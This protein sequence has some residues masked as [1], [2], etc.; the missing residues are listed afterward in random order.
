MSAPLPEKLCSWQLLNRLRE[1][2]LYISFDWQRG[3]TIKYRAA[4]D[5]QTLVKGVFVQL[6]GSFM[7]EGGIVLN[8]MIVTAPDAEDNTEIFSMTVSHCEELFCGIGKDPEFQWTQEEREQ[9]SFTKENGADAEL[10]RDQVVKIL[11]YIIAD[12]HDLKRN[13]AEIDWSDHDSMRPKAK[14]VKGGFKFFPLDKSSVYSVGEK[15]GEEVRAKLARG[16][17]PNAIKGHFTVE[18]NPSMEPG[19]DTLTFAL[20]E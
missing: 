13:G 19:D 20:D 7:Q 1:Y 6:D 17:S 12:N 4:D 11:A 8:F 14:K 9:L 3:S 15:L 2:C 18:V 16:I 5:S 10:I